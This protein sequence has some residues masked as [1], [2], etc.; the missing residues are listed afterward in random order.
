MYY[1]LAGC[2]HA[3]GKITSFLNLKQKRWG[4]FWERIIV[5]VYSAIFHTSWFLGNTL[6]YGNDFQSFKWMSR[7]STTVLVLKMATNYLLLLLSRRGNYFL[8]PWIYT[9]LWLA[10]DNRMWEKYGCICSR[11]GLQ[12]VFCMLQLTLSEYVLLYE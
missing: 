3:G 9:D 10:L 12:R 7:L 5:E 4:N 2:N 11:P 6:K 1:T 8:N